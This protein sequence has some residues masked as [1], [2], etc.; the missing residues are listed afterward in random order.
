M[1]GPSKGGLTVKTALALYINWLNN[2]KLNINFDHFLNKFTL[3]IDLEWEYLFYSSFQC[4]I[5]SWIDGRWNRTR[6]MCEIESVKAILFAKWI[7]NLLAFQ[8]KKRR[9]TNPPKSN[10]WRFQ[11]NFVLLPSTD[12]F[13]LVRISSFSF[14]SF[15]SHS[16]SKIH[17]LSSNV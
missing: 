11:S 13:L 6:H 16:N 1:P 2:L 5:N 10:E 3:K 9:T 8:E 14:R 12:L 17:N 15:A 7:C 4:V